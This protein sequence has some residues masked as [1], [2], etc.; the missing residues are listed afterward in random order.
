MSIRADELQ[1]NIS[2]IKQ[3][4]KDECKVIIDSPDLSNDEIRNFLIWFKNNVRGL[5]KLER[6]QKTIS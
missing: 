3:R 5:N 2:K 4:I 6:E 1:I